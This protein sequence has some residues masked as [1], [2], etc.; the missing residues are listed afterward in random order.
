MAPGSPF[1]C[2][3]NTFIR[4]ILLPRSS[5]QARQTGTVNFYREDKHCGFIARP[6]KPDLFFH[7]EGLADRYD[8]PETGDEVSFIEDLDRKLGKIRAVSVEKL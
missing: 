7:A 8:L 3:R 1:I 6:G 5:R 4:V 2:K